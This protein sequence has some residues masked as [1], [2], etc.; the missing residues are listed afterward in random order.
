MV[1]A[2]KKPVKKP[3]AKKGLIEI[4]AAAFNAPAKKKK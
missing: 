4:S 1:E 3:A 2:N